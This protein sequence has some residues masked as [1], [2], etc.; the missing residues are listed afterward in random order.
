[1]ATV[2]GKEYSWVSMELRV[3]GSAA[4]VGFT[5]IKYPWK[6]DH[7]KVMGA[8]RKALGMTRGRLMTDSGSLTLLESEYLN[9][10][11]APGWCDQTTEV[12]VSYAEPG[13]PTKVDTLK[14][15]KFTGADGGGEEGSEALKR[16]VSFE[17]TD[18]LV[19]GVSPIASV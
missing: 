10:S 11:S 7:S 3:G 13:L 18:I 4:I 2:N 5:A 15:V 19:N 8:S 17:F 12:I 6:V 9:L 14:G 1:M 16:E